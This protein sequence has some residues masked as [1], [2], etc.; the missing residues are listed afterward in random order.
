MAVLSVMTSILCY[1]S[2]VSKYKPGRC[3]RLGVSA[4]TSILAAGRH[5]DVYRLAQPQ[6]QGGWD[7]VCAHVVQLK[8]HRD[9]AQ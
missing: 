8:F 2:Y 6:G 7:K 1:S 9:S 3:S 5:L 4:L